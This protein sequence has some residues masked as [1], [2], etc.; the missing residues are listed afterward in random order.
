MAGDIAVFRVTN[1]GDNES[2]VGNS[3]KIEFNTGAVPDATGKM[4]ESSWQSR[5][6]LSIHPNPNRALNTIQDG[7]LGTIEVILTGYIKDPRSTVIPVNLFNWMSQTATNNDFK[8]GRF[9]IRNDDMS[10]IDL[11]PSA[12]LGYIL[13]DVYVQRVLNSPNEQGIIL[14]FYRT[15]SI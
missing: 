7:K 15:G 10:V 4:V 1:P 12:A 13:H 11:T 2:N 14:K 9:G 3:E 5:R 6:D 8:F